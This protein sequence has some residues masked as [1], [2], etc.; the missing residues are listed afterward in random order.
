MTAALI[1]VKHDVLNNAGCWGPREVSDTEY[2]N[3]GPGGE[4]RRLPG[5]PVRGC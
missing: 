1:K 4:R 5:D 3:S 2:S